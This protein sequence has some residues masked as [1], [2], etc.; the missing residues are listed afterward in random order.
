[1]GTPNIFAIVLSSLAI[2]LA[3]YV[4]FLQLRDYFRHLEMR[5]TYTHIAL[6]QDTIALIFVRISFANYA[7]RGRVV[8]W[9]QPEVMPNTAGIEEYQ[10]EFHLDSGHAIYRLAIG[11][12]Q[13]QIPIAELLLPPLDIPPRQCVHKWYPLALR[14]PSNIPDTYQVPVDFVA[15]GM[16]KQKLAYQIAV[17]PVIICPRKQVDVDMSHVPFSFYEPPPP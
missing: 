14:T 5:V 11:E 12:G 16:T 6:F 15:Q 8:S 4:S 3:G 17:A 9:I 10:Q 2:A 13:I 1:M 7:S